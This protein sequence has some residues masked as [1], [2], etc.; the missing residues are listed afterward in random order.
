MVPLTNTVAS[1]V[2]IIPYRIRLTLVNSMLEK[3]TNQGCSASCFSLLARLTADL[4]LE[5]TTSRFC[6]P[7]GKLQIWG[8]RNRGSAAKCYSSSASF[9]WW[10][11]NSSRCTTAPHW[12]IVYDTDL[13]YIFKKILSLYFHRMKFVLCI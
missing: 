12:T 4:S 13:I 2:K 9:L 5:D 8:V 10:L 11:E 7:M 6:Q 1:A 3:L